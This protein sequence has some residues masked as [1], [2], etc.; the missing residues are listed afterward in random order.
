MGNSYDSI[1]SIQSQSCFELSSLWKPI[2]G[3]IWSAQRV[4]AYWEIW[5]DCFR[6]LLRS[7]SP[8]S[9]GKEDG[10]MEEIHLKKPFIWHLEGQIADHFLHCI[11]TLCCPF[12]FVKYRE[13]DW[14]QKELWNVSKLV[15]GNYPKT[16]VSKQKL[17]DSMWKCNYVETESMF[18]S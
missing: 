11:F 16:S 13:K 5:L 10:S 15:R 17:L 7:L 12:K 2:F 4:K 9:W 3:W 6:K 1:E 14:L 18:F 8:N